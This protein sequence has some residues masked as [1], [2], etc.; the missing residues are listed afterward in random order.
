MSHQGSG[1]GRARRDSA[2]RAM[3]G[4]H[5]QRLAGSRESAETSVK[6]SLSS[7]Y[8]H[9]PDFSPAEASSLESITMFSFFGFRIR[10]LT[11]PQSIR[12]S[13]ALVHLFLKAFFAIFLLARVA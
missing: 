12:N 6:V 5:T 9:F 2:T 1:S 13:K 4:W 10:A 8:P 7:S 11:Q 3:Q